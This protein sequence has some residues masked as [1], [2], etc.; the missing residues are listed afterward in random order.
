[1]RY[2]IVSDLHA[3]LQ[4]WKAVLIDIRSSDVDKIICLGDIVGY[5]PDPVRVLESVHANVDHFV[6]GNHEAAVTGKLDTSLFNDSARK[7]VDWTRRRLNQEALAFLG[8]FPLSLRG[9]HFRCTHGDFSDPG[10]FHYVIDPQDAAPSWQTV[11]EPL[12]FVGHTHR[13]AIF[14]LGASGTP[15]MVEPQDFS[16]EDTRRH[17]VNVGSVGQPRDGEARACYVILDTD[18]K[19]VHWRRVPFDLDAYAAGL[20]AA[21]L[22]DKPAYFLRHD[23]RK[24]AP[25]LRQLLS[26]SPATQESQ[27]ARDVVQVQDLQG[28]RRR[29]SWWK[30]VTL[31]VV[32]TVVL[33][34]TAAGTIAWR[35]ATRAAAFAAPA[36]WPW[37]AGWPVL[38]GNR[39]KQQVSML[40]TNGEAVLLLE[41]STARDEIVLSSPERPAEQHDRWLRIIEI[42]PAGRFDGKVETVL[43]L[44]KNVD[45]EPRVMDNFHVKEPNQNRAAGWL[46]AEKTVDIPARSTSIQHRIRAR[47][48]GRVLV[49]SIRLE[50]RQ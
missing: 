33:T 47:F 22:P 11:S 2:A 40:T 28:L 14:L 41:S 16:I 21:G 29:V 27:A 6:L 30:R 19:A 35:H 15:R 10:A 18:R 43:S 50:R 5:G 24:G 31:S 46:R 20:R 1:V 26:F 37:V 48:T 45:G 23:P 42:K 25:P 38:L 4:A 44:V 9:E 3:N 49:R 12:L 34:G 32:A 17:L 13:S 8:S 39:H 36:S 7:V